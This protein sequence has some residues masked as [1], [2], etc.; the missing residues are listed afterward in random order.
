VPRK[1]SRAANVRTDGEHAG[2]L[3][4]FRSDAAAQMGGSD[5]REQ[6]VHRQVA[7]RITRGAAARAAEAKAR[8]STHGKSGGEGPPHADRLGEQRHAEKSEAK[9]Q[10]RR[11][12]VGEYGGC[13]LAAGAG[14]NDHGDTSHHD[15][16][17][18]KVPEANGP[19]QWLAVVTAVTTTAT[20]A[21]RSG[22]S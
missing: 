22:R 8:R 17:K 7:P 11:L 13:R 5:P 21:A 6:S 4:R 14:M 1:I 19:I 16:K 2:S 15:R 3:R 20:A 12:R 9:A 10:E 18:A